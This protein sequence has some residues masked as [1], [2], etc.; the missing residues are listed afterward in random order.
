[1]VQPDGDITVL[2]G[3]VGQTETIGCSR[4]VQDTGFQGAERGHVKRVGHYAYHQL[5]V[6]TSRT[7]RLEAQLQ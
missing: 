6:R 1:M 4:A 5:V 3:S 7:A 2:A